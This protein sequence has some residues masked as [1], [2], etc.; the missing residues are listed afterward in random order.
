M[1]MTLCSQGTNQGFAK[2][3]VANDNNHTM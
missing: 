3:N 1:P 2:V